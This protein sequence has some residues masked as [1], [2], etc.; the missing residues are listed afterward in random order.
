LD[1]EGVKIS[2][3]PAD[4]D[5]EDKR[6]F[7]PEQKVGSF[8][9][10][11]QYTLP[12]R[13]LSYRHIRLFINAQDKNIEDKILKVVYELPTDFLQNKATV[14][15]RSSDFSLELAVK[16]VKFEVKAKIFWREKSRSPTTLDTTVNLD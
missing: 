6:L 12:E 11:G 7:A 4:E 2:Y 14:N 10:R 13:N 1:K 8:L 9:T 5:R 3:K 15:D 16:E